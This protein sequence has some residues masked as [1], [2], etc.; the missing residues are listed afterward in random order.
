VLTQAD[1]DH[2][3]APGASQRRVPAPRHSLHHCAAPLDEP[4]TRVQAIHPSDLP[5]ARRPWMDHGRLRLSPELRTPRLLAAHVGAGTDQLSTDP[6]SASTASAEPPTSRIYLV[7]AT[8][9]RTRGCDSLGQRARG[10]SRLRHRPGWLLTLMRTV[11]QEQFAARVRRRV[12]GTVRRLG[13]RE[14]E[15]DEEPQREPRVT[16]R[17]TLTYI[18]VRYMVVV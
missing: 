16:C 1:H 5:L 11:G 14:G 17:L 3:P 4:S 7:R 13:R 6:K 18:L 10:W 15:A 9:C 2:R 12:R 8:S